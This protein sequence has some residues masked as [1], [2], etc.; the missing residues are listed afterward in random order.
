[1]ESV[2]DIHIHYSFEI[3]LPKTVEIFR[4]EFQATGTKKGCFLSLPHHEENGKVG[5]AETQNIKGLYLKWAFAPDFYAFGGLVHPEDHSDKKA[6]AKEFLRQAEEYLS[7]GYDGMKMLDGYPSLLK[8]WGLGI[9]DE[10]YD[11]YYA[12]MEENGYPIIMHIA[13]PNENWDITKAS[14]FAIQAGR[15]YDNTY[16]TKEEITAQVFRVMKKFPRLKLILAHWGFFSQ[17]RENA[18]RFLGEYEN[19]MLD[20]TPGGEQYL[21]MAK[22]WGYWLGFIE[23][24]QQR[25]LHG[26]DLYAFPDEKEEEWRTSFLRRPQFIRHFFEKDS[27]STYLE[28]RFCGVKL[29]KGLRDQ[30]YRKNAEVLLGQPHTI[31]LAYMRSETARLLL[32][33]KKQ[34]KYADVDLK[35]ILEHI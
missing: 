15:V 11:R 3:P 28:E 2:F 31:D 18:E 24:Y 35:Y 29:D 30:I 34:E 23:K 20:I 1:M 9:D 6:V 21:I 7:V 10:I 26:T 8:A 5:C 14:K 19:T 22:D 12:F 13:N 32:L 25:I 17:E 16:P 27:E 33:P 4:K